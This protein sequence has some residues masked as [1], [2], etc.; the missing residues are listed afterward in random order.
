MKNLKKWLAVLMMVALAV[1]LTACSGGNSNQTAAPAAETK[2]ETGSAPA[3]GDNALVETYGFQWTDTSAP[4]LNEQGAKDISFNIYS[5]KNA[6]AL[7]Y[8]D[9]KIM[10]DLFAQTNVRVN[11]ENVS[12]S[13]YS[14]QKNLI[15]GNADNRPDAIYHAGM[16]S[17]EII[18]YAKRKVLV[19]ISDYLQY[20]PNF[21][22][23]LEE[24]PDIKNQLLNV[25]DGKIYSLPR[26]EEMGLLQSPNLLFLNVAWTK[27]AIE[28][29]AVS[30]LT[31][32][33]LTDG[34][35]LTSKQMEEILTYF[36]DN[37]MNENGKTDDE[38]PLIF[39]YNNWQGN[40]C[41]LYGMFGLNDNLEH[42][43][44]VDGKVTYTVQDERFKEATNFIAG[45]V[46]KGLIDKVSFEQSQDNFLANGK[47]VETYGAFY[48]W[49]S[50][51]VVSN[52]ENYIV[53][54]PLIGPN[55]DQTI[56]VSN[57]PE[58]STG[59]VILFSNCKYPEVLLAYFDRYY[60]P[61]ISAQINYGPIGIVY[62]EERDEKGMLVQKPLPEGVTSDELRLQNAP[63]GIINLG[64]YAWNNVVNMEPR[65][66]LRLER[67]QQCA[68]PFVTKGVTPFPNLQFNLE[69]L[70]TLSNYETNLNDY[71]RTNLISWL[72]KGGVSDAEWT[73]FQNDLNGKVN[74]EGIRTVYQ[75]AYDRYAQANQ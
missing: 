48:W 1:T 28:A 27:K 34:L 7:D 6:S 37:D 22:K 63:L 9:M 55:G 15:F 30:D 12:E 40:Q 4:I 72:M 46:D 73:A 18:K 47:G 13:V 32:D 61:V 35:A 16:G 43:V 45:W 49:E 64:E 52:P 11:W 36:R 71:I 66:K 39:V 41:D 20:M 60:D 42:R 58:I 53:C 5:S 31:A 17:G 51:T 70:N 57:N 54:S 68:L 44:I 21:S 14:Q 25:E 74:L 75:N 8:N 19:P 69:E 23:L 10:N 26:I 62:E 2:E 56:C 3:A 65:A 59:E 33:Q 29:G 38:R 24:R 50:E 67:L